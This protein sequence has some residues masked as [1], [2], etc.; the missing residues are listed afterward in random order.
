MANKKQEKAFD[1]VK[2]MRDI[3][4]KISAETQG[5]SFDELKKYIEARVPKNIVHH[6]SK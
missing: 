4:D 1:A 2:M 3:R 5:M 6:P